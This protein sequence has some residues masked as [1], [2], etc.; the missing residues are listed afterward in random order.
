MT[1]D[2]LLSIGFPKCEGCIPQQTEEW[3]GIIQAISDFSGYN[4]ALRV[5]DKTV[6]SQQSEEYEPVLQ[7]VL[8]ASPSC[9]VV[10]NESIARAHLILRK[11]Q[12]NN[13][14]VAVVVNLGTVATLAERA[15][16]VHLTPNRLIS[17]YPITQ[18]S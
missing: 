5:V 4:V 7:D 9:F 11:I 16:Y 14:L 12:E 13:G 2:F 17:G 3:M 8:T 18:Q 1:F 15:L 10:T 6:Q